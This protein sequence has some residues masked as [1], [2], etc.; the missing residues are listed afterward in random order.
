MS[1]P[2]ARRLVRNRHATFERE[3]RL[4]ARRARREREDEIAHEDDRDS[5]P[6]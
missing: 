5:D 2:R 1:N 3:E 4:A 6:E